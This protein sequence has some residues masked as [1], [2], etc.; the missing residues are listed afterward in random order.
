VAH[1]QSYEKGQEMRRRLLGD[2]YV[3]RVNQSTYT[4]PIMR[5]FIDVA[6]ET[7]FGT[8]WSRPGLD[9]KTRTLVTLVS[10]AATGRLPELAIHL[11]MAL[12]QGWTEE[13]LTE[14]LIHLMGY[15]GAPLTRDALLT[16]RDVFAEVK[17]EGG[18]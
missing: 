17:K 1:S 6:T 14:V 16:A 12:R 11:R 18:R 7:V 10:D 2:A 13:E 9:L 3:E 8:L 15:V 4:D 5:T